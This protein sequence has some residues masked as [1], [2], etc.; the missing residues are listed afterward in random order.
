MEIK[1]HC[2]AWFLI[3]VLEEFGSVAD[4]YL[5]CPFSWQILDNRYL[6]KVIQKSKMWVWS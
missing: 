2:Q 3:F 6:I 5:F 4:F 1:S